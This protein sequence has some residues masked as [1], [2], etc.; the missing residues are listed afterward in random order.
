MWLLPVILLL[1][2]GIIGWLLVRDSNRSA[3]RVMLVVGLLLTV[4][5]MLTA[6]PTKDLLGVLGGAG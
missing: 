4:A 5:T 6:G 1:P 2:G 3:G